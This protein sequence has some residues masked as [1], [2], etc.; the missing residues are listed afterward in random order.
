MPI[1][2]CP[3]EIDRLL[4]KCRTAWAAYE[5]ALRAYDTAHKLGR[6]LNRYAAAMADARSSYL[7]AQLELNRALFGRG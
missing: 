1:S 7:D 2:Q 6:E 5:D 4:T 3:P